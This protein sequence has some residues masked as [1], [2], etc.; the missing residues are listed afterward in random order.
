MVYLDERRIL[1]DAH[2]IRILS[3]VIRMHGD[4]GENLISTPEGLTATLLAEGCYS[5]PIRIN[6]NAI[7]Q[8]AEYLRII[9][10][11]DVPNNSRAVAEAMANVAALVNHSAQD[12]CETASESEEIDKLSRKIFAEFATACAL[13][14]ASSYG[15]DI[16]IDGIPQDQVSLALFTRDWELLVRIFEASVRLAGQAPATPVQNLLKDSA[17][18]VIQS[19]ERQFAEASPIPE[20]NINAGRLLSAESYWNLRSMAKRENWSTTDIL[21]LIDE[22]LN[23]KLHPHLIHHSSIVSGDDWQ[24]L[25][26]WIH[27]EDGHVL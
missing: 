4:V 3:W 20:A 2:L 14:F 5:V 11:A 26:N 25:Y 23:P 18:D 13:S 7:V 9:T 1:G 10:A 17:E 22:H 19:L 16:P 24:R 27:R 21:M 15:Y 6:S 8:L 12:V